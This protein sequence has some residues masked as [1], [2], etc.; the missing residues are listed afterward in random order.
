MFG[1]SQQAVEYGRIMQKLEDMQRQ[2]DNLSTRF[3]FRLDDLEQ[4]VE[5][6]E[7]NTASR[8]WSHQVIEKGVWAAAGA[9]AIALMK[10][11][12]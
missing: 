7:V 10:V 3:V 4:R 11:V 5:K 2:L 6:L 1:D 9:V 12:G 8:G